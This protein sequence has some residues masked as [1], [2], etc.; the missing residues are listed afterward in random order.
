MNPLTHGSKH[1]AEYQGTAVDA[2]T[3]GVAML[4][5]CIRT[6]VSYG[7][8]QRTQQV[9]NSSRHSLLPLTETAGKPWQRPMP[10][11]RIDRNYYLCIAKGYLYA[12]CRQYW[13]FKISAKGESK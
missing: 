5:I 1:T 10:N 6:C 4:D 7:R 11:E 8:V 13:N 12:Y 2:W 3:L 9:V